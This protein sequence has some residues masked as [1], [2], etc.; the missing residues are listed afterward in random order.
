VKTIFP[1]VEGSNLEKENISI[2]EGLEGRSNIV[3]IAFKRYQQFL[4]NQWASVLADM[5]KEYPFFEFYE[6]PTLAWGYKGMS[7]VIDGGMRAGIPNKRTREKTITLYLNKSKF[8]KQLD[9][10][11][12]ETIYLYLLTKDGEI[13]WQEKGRPNKGKV[14]RLEEAL[15]AFQKE[16]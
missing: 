8:K 3:I 15:Q 11:S 7:F 5:Q 16:S 1:R 12:E 9:I 10:P 13:I 6:L 14:K 2:P 4:V